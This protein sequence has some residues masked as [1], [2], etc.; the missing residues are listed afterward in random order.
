M[1]APREGC[2]DAAGELDDGS[3]QGGGVVE[4]KLGA[5][6]DNGVISNFKTSERHGRCDSVGFSPLIIRC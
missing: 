5:V 3:E 1:G 4:G 6:A 2:S